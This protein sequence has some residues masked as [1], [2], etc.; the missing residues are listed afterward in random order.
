MINVMPYKTANDRSTIM[1]RLVELG[2]LC[3]SRSRCLMRKNPN[4]D[5]RV[6]VEINNALNRDSLLVVML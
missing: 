6:P 3:L 5:N 4:K 1:I 2:L